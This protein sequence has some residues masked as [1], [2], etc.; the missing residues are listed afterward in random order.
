MLHWL[1]PLEQGRVLWSHFWSLQALGDNIW[2]Q[3]RHAWTIGRSWTDDPGDW[4]LFLFAAAEDQLV[5]A[6]GR[7][8]PVGRDAVVIAVTTV[9]G[10]GTG[11]RDGW[12]W[13]CRAT[14]EVVVLEWRRYGNCADAASPSAVCDVGQTI[15]RDVA[16]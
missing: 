12:H 8:V 16:T 11:L 2:R 3:Q 1:G 15:R 10:D 9:F 6:F 14:V 5:A 13:C 7:D 4:R